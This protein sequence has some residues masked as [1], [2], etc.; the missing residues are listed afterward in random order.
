MGWSEKV[1]KRQ[2]NVTFWQWNWIRSLGELQ[3]TE[4]CDIISN[5]LLSPLYRR[6]RRASESSELWIFTYVQTELW[7]II[8]V[9]CFLGQL[10][11]CRISQ[12]C[13]T[14]D[15]VL[16][17]S[18]GSMRILEEVNGQR[19]SLMF[20]NIEKPSDI[21]IRGVEPPEI[22]RIR[23]R[24]IPRLPNLLVRRSSKFLKYA[25]DCCLLEKDKLVATQKCW[26]SSSCCVREF[27]YCPTSMIVSQRMKNFRIPSK[28][29]ELVEKKVSQSD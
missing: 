9:R 11:H 19:V 1:N 18:H 7:F 12:T 27:V 21:I 24:A 14:L 23:A 28:S 26:N 8:R 13:N 3:C 6:S 20:A 15:F 16:V 29:S 10:V 5:Y 2:R 17:E 25:S 4:G 22:V